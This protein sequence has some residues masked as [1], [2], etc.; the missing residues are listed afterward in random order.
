MLTKKVLHAEPYVEE[1]LASNGKADGMLIR[2]FRFP[3]AYDVRETLMEH[4]HG[5]FRYCRDRERVEALFKRYGVTEVHLGTWARRQDDETLFAFVKEL[6]D[7]EGKA[8]WTGFRILGTIQ[9]NGYP[10][11]TLELFL[12]LPGLTTPVYTGDDAP[13]VLHGPRPR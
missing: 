1:A 5:G 6:A 11:W 4:L 8:V 10:F 9:M 3:D 13:N 2:Q 7:P 12:K